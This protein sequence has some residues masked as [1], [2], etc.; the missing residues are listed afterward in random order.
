MINVLILDDD[1]NAVEY[2]QSVIKKNIPQV[3]A[4]FA[5]TNIDEAQSFLDARKPELVF[6]DVEMPMMTGFEFLARQKNK[7]FNVIFST[8][9]SKYAIQAIRFSALDFL[10]KPV[11]TDELITAFKRFMEQPA[12][13]EQKQKIYEHL[14]ENLKANDERAFKLSVTKGSRAYFIPP[15]DIYYC[16]AYSNY[17]NLH[18]KDKS[19]FTVSKTLKEIE[20]MLAAH[21]FIRTHKSYL[22]NKDHIKSC[23][24]VGNLI[25]K[26]D[27]NIEVSRRRLGEVRRMLQ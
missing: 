16:S 24:E 20:E 18:L 2:L 15:S 14:F 26:N 3:T 8:A 19:E 5:T 17:T 9:Y 10:L 13:M 12:E 21:N 7:N 25:L 1:I 11:Q 27:L 23:D 4:I 22:V 6:L